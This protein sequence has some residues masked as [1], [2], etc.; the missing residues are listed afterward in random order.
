MS[1]LR[2][3]FRFG[4]TFV[5]RRGDLRG[6]ETTGLLTPASTMSDILA[7]RDV[8]A[9]IRLSD[10]L[11]GGGSR[12]TP[13]TRRDVEHAKQAVERALLRGELVGLRRH[14]PRS[15]VSGGGATVGPHTPRQEEG[16][17]AAP[18]YLPP[19][20][21]GPQRG[22]WRAGTP[23]SGGGSRR[24]LAEGKPHPD[25]LCP[26]AFPRAPVRTTLHGVMESG[27]YTTD[28]AAA[29]AGV[30]KSTVYYWAR[31]GVL[32][33]SV[34]CDKPKLWSYTDLLRLRVVQWLRQ[35]KPG[36]HGDEIAATSMRVVRKAL[37]TLR[38]KRLPILF[39][40]QSTPLR[41]GLD[42]NVWIE[43]PSGLVDPVGQLGMRDVLDPVAPFEIPGV[44]TRG[45]DLVH[46]RPHLLI[47]P[48]KLSGSPHIQHTRVETL[49]LSALRETGYSNEKLI[50][51]YP[52]LA[53]DDVAQ[54]LDLEDQLAEN[55][56]QAA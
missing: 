20:E 55:L 2:S 12:F 11:R 56:R 18:T 46:P 41:V 25:V 22:A 48:G 26:L 47:R 5:K 44:H 30:P 13:P 34:S 6:N 39:A 52:Y 4:E 15:G 3:V 28:R 1:S 50:E 42:G 29:L 17:P 27:A 35:P 43:Q 9:L 23:T 54:S 40:D 36:R 45:P 19:A 21:I 10:D 8:S 32:T 33:P 38:E 37:D 49:A 51:L 7:A 53:V 31:T 16:I 14:A 24:S